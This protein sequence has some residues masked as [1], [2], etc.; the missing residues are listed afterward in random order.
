M[1]PSTYLEALTLCLI[2]FVVYA[3]LFNI[4]VEIISTPSYYLQPK[5]EVP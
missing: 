3:A 1:Y 5:F 2:S 4:L